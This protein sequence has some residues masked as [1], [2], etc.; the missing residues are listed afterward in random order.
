M[1]GLKGFS[2][3]VSPL[4]LNSLYF[5]PREAVEKNYPHC[6]PLPEIPL[7]ALDPAVEGVVAFVAAVGLEVV[8]PVVHLQMLLLVLF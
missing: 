7:G 2:A 6:S 3:S 1:E 8:E 5:S 4:S